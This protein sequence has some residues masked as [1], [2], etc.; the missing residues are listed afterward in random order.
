[1]STRP[2]LDDKAIATV[3]AALQ[4]YQENIDAV[5]QRITEI[6]TNKGQWSGLNASDIDSLCEQLAAK[7]PT[8]PSLLAACK[9]IVDLYRQTDQ[10]D[11]EIEHPLSGADAVEALAM[12][13][14]RYEPL[15]TQANG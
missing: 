12:W 15:I 7:E 11:P 6:A 13:V 1:M 2:Q 3:L 5:P 14:S 8:E 9:E 4:Y 10:D